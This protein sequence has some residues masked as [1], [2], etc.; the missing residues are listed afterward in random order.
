[1]KHRFA[2]AVAV[3]ALITTIAAP[4]LANPGQPSFGEELYADGDVWGTKAAAQLPAPND[5]NAQS[6]DKLFVI[7]NSNNPATQ[8]PVAEAAPG[9]GFNGGRW[10]TQTVTWT[11][12]GFDAHGI[13]PILTSYEDVMTHYSLGHLTITAG[14]PGG[15]GTP[16]DYFLCPLLPVK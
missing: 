16:P 10:A 11:Q 13:V 7:T 6:F 15:P 12:A 1:M 9:R 5:H 2:L 14:S 4:A 8:L 3:A